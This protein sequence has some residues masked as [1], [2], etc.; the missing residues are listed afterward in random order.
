MDWS[1]RYTAT[2]GN[3]AIVALDWLPAEPPLRPRMKIVPV[4]GL[5]P[6]YVTF[7]VYFSRSS[8]VETLSCCSWSPVIA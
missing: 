5:L 3:G 4:P 6:P 7:G 2:F 1:S 8:N